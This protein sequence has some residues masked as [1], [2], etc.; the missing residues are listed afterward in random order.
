MSVLYSEATNNFGKHTVK[1]YKLSRIYNTFK[2]RHNI[3][4][5]LDDFVLK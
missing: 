1:A 4:K 5:I 3:F 2:E